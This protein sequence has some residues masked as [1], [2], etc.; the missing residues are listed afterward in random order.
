MSDLWAQTVKEIRSVL[1]ESTGDP[2]SSSTAA[3]A[4]D[5][6]TQI[7]SDHMPPTEVGRGYRPTICMSWNEVS[8]KGFQ[9]EV[10]EDKYEFYRFFEGRTEIA[11]LHHRAGDDFPPETLEKLHIISMIV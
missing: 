7:R 9:I 2:V 4:W 11:E 10:H 6:V 5:L 3:N 1:E 8:P